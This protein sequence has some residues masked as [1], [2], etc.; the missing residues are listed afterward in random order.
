MADRYNDIVK[1]RRALASEDEYPE[2]SEDMYSDTKIQALP[3]EEKSNYGGGVAASQMAGGASAEDAAAA[4][5]MS[6]GNPYAMGAGAGLAV[7]SAG[8]KRR[9]QQKMLDYQAKQDRIQKQQQ[10]ISRLIGITDSM[11]AL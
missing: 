3:V 5:L 7:L 2:V 11:R 6:S 4:G 10:A 8:A 1:R 9:D